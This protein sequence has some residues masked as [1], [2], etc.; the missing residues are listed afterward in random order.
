MGDYRRELEMNG[1]FVKL[2]RLT[3][4]IVY[5]NTC[6]HVSSH[7]IK[8]SM[9]ACGI[10]W[11]AVAKSAGLNVNPFK[12]QKV[13]VTYKSRGV[14][15]EEQLLQLWECQDKFLQPLF[16]VGCA[17]ALRL[18]DCCTL[19]ADELDLKACVIRRIQRKT[20]KP[21]EVQLPGR[22][23]EYLSTFKPDES[24]FMFPAQA[25]MYKTNASGVYYRTQ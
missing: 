13:D 20:G 19:R 24:G 16:R 3:S 23:V 11:G 17:T 12:K 22:L 21:V 2:K 9:M 4:G 5:R 8:A 1:R 25:A 7:T 10:V 15:T 6:D 18:G 14:F